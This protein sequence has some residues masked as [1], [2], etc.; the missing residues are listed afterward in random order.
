MQLKID[1]ELSVPL[2]HQISHGIL[3]IVRSG[4]FKPG[5]RLFTEVGLCE[6][7]GVSLAPGAAGDQ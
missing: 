6:K 1:A 7:Y 4:K 3:S 2:H 5:D